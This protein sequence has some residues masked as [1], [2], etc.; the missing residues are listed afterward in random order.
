MSSRDV[1]LQR[2]RSPQFHLVKA[3]RHLKDRCLGLLSLSSPAQPCLRSPASRSFLNPL[4]RFAPQSLTCGMGNEGRHGCHM[5]YFK[6]SDLG[7]QAQ[8]KG[9][10]FL[11]LPGSPRLSLGGLLLSGSVLAR[12][13]LL[14]GTLPPAWAPLRGR[15][16][17]LHWIPANTATESARHVFPA[18]CHSRCR[19]CNTS[20]LGGHPT[21]LRGL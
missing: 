3:N 13:C 18:I 11:A 6:A 4:M 21:P 20:S 17:S 2:K 8:I 1:P 9:S 7:C 10:P 12:A 14:Q 16:T 5:G 15:D 19:D